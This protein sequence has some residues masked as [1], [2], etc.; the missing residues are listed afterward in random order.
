M[1]GRVQMQFRGRTF[2]CIVSQSSLAVEAMLQ[3]VG[4]AFSG[5]AEEI[6]IPTWGRDHQWP[7]GR[8]VDF[9]GPQQTQIEKPLIL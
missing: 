6:E 4:P 5:P 2:N 3:P 1:A 7:T 8:E 9:L